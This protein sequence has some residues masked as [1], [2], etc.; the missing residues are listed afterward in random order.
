MALLVETPSKSEQE[1]R[2]REEE[3]RREGGR[4]R[5]GV[6]NILQSQLNQ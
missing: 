5:G 6:A 4:A 2:R 1:E 3:E